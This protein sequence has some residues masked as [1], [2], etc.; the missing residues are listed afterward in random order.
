MRR[1]QR[2]VKQDDPADPNVPLTWL[3]KRDD[4]VVGRTPPQQH[5]QYKQ[6]EIAGT[7]ERWF[8][9]CSFAGAITFLLE[10]LGDKNVDIV[11]GKEGTIRVPDDLVGSWVGVHGCIAGFL[12][13]MLGIGYLNVVGVANWQRR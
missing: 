11:E 2:Y 12:K 4:I 6:I 9:H 10:V 1:E 7:G 5:G 3:F 13:N 8:V